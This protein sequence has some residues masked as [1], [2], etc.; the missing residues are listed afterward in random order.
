MS[1][2]N[3]ALAQISTIRSQLARVTRFRGY[4]PASIAAGGSLALAAAALEARMARPPQF[5]LWPFLGVWTLV[6]G[7]AIA[8][9]AVEMVRR[10][11]RAH[12]S[13]AG[14]MIQ[15]A[16]AQFL[17]AVGVGLLLTVVLV[18]IAPENGWM[19][20]GLWQLFFGL[21]IFASCR[22]LPRATFVAGVWYLIAG[23]GCLIVGASTHALSP[24]EMG[25]PF[26]IGQCLVAAILHL[27]DDEQA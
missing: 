11:K 19:L 7:I 27:G 2:L 4:G 6:A 24:W 3:D 17:P 8:F 9:A 25:I 16:A 20:P 23:L 18:R 1:E 10:A 22:F 5:A 14:E 21:G 15:A 13:F 12:S 26:G